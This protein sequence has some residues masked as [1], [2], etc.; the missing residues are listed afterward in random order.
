MLGDVC[1]KFR[2]NEDQVW[3][4]RFSINT[5]SVALVNRATFYDAFHSC[6]WYRQHSLAGEMRMLYAYMVKPF[7]SR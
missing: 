4:I 3:K 6:S 2:L 1:R 7:S 5:S